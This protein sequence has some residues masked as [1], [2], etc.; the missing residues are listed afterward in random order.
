MKICYAL[1]VGIVF[2]SCSSKTYDGLKW[3][4]KKVTIDGDIEE[5][6]VPL[7]YFDNTTQL[8]YE[9]SNDNENLY[10]AA[11]TAKEST[12]RQILMSGLTIEI[13]TSDEEGYYPFGL[14]YPAERK[15]IKAKE[16]KTP[17]EFDM[18][19]DH[20]KEPNKKIPED[21][22]NINFSETQFTE[23]EL[24]GFANREDEEEIVSLSEASGILSKVDI[25]STDVLFFEAIIPFE[26]FY[27]DHISLVDTSV[28]FRFKI[29]TENIQFSS[30]HGPPAGQDTPP[31][32]E[33]GGENRR[34]PGGP[35]PAG[36]FE[37]GS[38]PPMNGSPGQGS[39][40]GN[41]N[42]E[43]S[44]MSERNEITLKLHLVSK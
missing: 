29:S 13:D 11:K 35:P 24:H 16:P 38:R 1:L 37:P 28:I 14:R 18:A 19:K 39:P 34:G 44:N 31:E 33:P 4:S 43:S 10:F 27:K 12:V 30:M 23:I 21:F 17:E 9:F 15:L 40:E 6:Q 8:N 7:K 3:Q 36:G 32:G 2:L 42:R 41:S 26:T 5:W 20:D 25:D 22:N